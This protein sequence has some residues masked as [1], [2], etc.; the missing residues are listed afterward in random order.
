MYEVFPI[1]F[2]LIIKNLIS[3]LSLYNIIFQFSKETVNERDYMQYM[4]TVGC[5]H[6]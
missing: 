2:M 5:I 4:I 1:M 6:A 3:F